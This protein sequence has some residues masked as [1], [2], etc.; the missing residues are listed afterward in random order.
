MREEFLG[1][2]DASKLKTHQINLEW[3]VSWLYQLLFKRL[4]NSGQEMTEYL[5]LVPNL[6]KGN[7]PDLGVIISAEE[8]LFESMM[9][10][11]IGKFM[12]ANARKGYTY[13]WIPNHLQDAGSRIAPRSFLKLF[14]LAGNIRLKKFDEQSLPEEKLLQP[15]DLQG[16]LME[17]SED[18]IQELAYEE[19][20]WLEP[21]KTSLRGLEVPIEKTRFLDALNSTRWNEQEGKCPPT[22]K[23]E[24]IFNYLLQLGI[25][26]SRSDGR[27]NMP[28]IYLYGFGVK[29][30][31]G[32]KRPK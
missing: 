24:E 26:D 11:I 9:E 18:R 14:S 3:K 30:R 12:G 21:M 17:T 4:A 1:F 27:I 31:G 23:P 16:A 13:R 29:R 6:I 20:P 28:E 7:H 15:S 25:L 8:S 2:P 32:I 5:H 19:Y 10:T 22:S